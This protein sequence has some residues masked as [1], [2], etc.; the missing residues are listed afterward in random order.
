MFK[1]I[2]VFLMISVFASS[3]FAEAVTK[4][5]TSQ[6]NLPES[7]KNCTII[8]MKSSNFIPTVL[9]VTQ[10]PNS[11]TETTTGGKNPVRVISN[12]IDNETVELKQ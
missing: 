5:V 2:F 9:F 10:C 8:M 1:N 6:F 11:K 4:D 3:A 7:M 12:S